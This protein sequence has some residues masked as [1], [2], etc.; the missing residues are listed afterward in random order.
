MQVGEEGG[1]VGEEEGAVSGFGELIWAWGSDGPFTG[2]ERS[3]GRG[4]PLTPVEMLP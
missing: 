4:L 2:L 3:R 1:A